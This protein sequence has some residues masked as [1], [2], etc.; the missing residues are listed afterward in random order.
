MEKQE[1]LTQ[2]VKD[3][4]AVLKEA[5][6]FIDEIIVYMNTLAKE[7]RVNKLSTQDH[8]VIYAIKFAEEFES[9]STQEKVAEE[10]KRILNL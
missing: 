9:V 4:K 10:L 3:A 1:G 6:E 7:T 2:T 8:K 5:L